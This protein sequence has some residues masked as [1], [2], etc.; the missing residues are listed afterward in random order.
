VPART[1]LASQPSL[2]IA[3]TDCVA[4][5]NGFTLGIAVRSRHNL[6]HR[7]M[8]FGPPMEGADDRA[9]QIGIKFAGGREGTASGHGPNADVMA[10]YKAW[11]DDIEP[12]WPAGPVVSH[13]KGGGGDRRTVH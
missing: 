2:V 3:L 13:R 10:Y 7:S 5:G 8:G 6:D 12:E 4:Y 11:R 1:V 9:L